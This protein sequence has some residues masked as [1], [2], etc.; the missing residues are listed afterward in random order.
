[1][2]ALTRYP[3]PRAIAAG[4]VGGPQLLFRLE[5]TI[6]P[7]P[8]LDFLRPLR[9][10][11]QGIAA[12]KVDG[13]RLYFRLEPAPAPVLEF[14]QPLRATEQ[15]AAA[16]K[17]DDPRLH[18][19]LEPTIVPDPVLDFLQPLRGLESVKAGAVD[20]PRLYFRLEVIPPPTLE[21]LRPRR[22]LEVIEAGAVDDPRL[23]FR[24]EP[25]VVPDP[26]LDFL[27]PLR[28]LESVKAGTVDEPRLY[29]RLIPTEAVT[30]TPAGWPEGR[31][32]VILPDGQ[33]LHLTPREIV[34]VRQQLEAE[35]AKQLAE[36]EAKSTRKRKKAKR[37]IA[38]Q[39][40]QIEVAGEPSIPLPPRISALPG[41]GAAPDLEA[42]IRQ[43][44]RVQE[45][46]ALL[47]LLMVS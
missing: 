34:I 26:V 42:A 3:V 36:I 45:N 37:L 14:L 44:L 16:G 41:Y 6:V 24:L 43:M 38:A 29:F 39:V 7:A 10:T 12:G 23:Y 28:G 1:M 20:N 22:G 40:R 4:A 21:F 25:T 19:R 11:E 32:R 27:R 35:Q 5:P 13:S 47:V 8:V 31:K 33:V 18:F 9:A 46:D 30:T 17:V 2:S 15:R